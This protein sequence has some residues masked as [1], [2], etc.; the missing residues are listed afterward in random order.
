MKKTEMES[1][2]GEEKELLM[3]VAKEIRYGP[4]RIQPNLRYTD[5]TKVRAAIVKINKLE[6]PINIEAITE[7]N[8]VL[9]AAGNIVAEMVRH[10]DKVMTRT[11][12]QIAKEQSYRSR[13]YYTKSL[14]QRVLH[15]E[16]RQLNRLKRRELLN[17][18][19]ISKL[20]RKFSVKRKSTKVVRQIL[21]AVGAKLETYDNKVEQYKQKQLF[22]SNQKRLFNELEETQTQSVIPDT[23]ENR[24]F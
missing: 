14:E 4:E 2:N 10:K 18:S 20:E 24:R 23:V 7:I 13:K 19:V 11:S 3:R 17:E 22:E 8:S 9:L 21:F 16:L 5:E 1:Y 6:S 15:K 12:S